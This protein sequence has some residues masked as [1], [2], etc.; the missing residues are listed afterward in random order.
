MHTQGDVAP[1]NMQ[2]DLIPSERGEG[3]A[4]RLKNLANHGEVPHSDHSRPAEKARPDFWSAAGAIFA[5]QDHIPRLVRCAQNGPVP[6][7]LAQERLWMLEQS[8]P[9][10]PYYHIPLT[11]KITG[12]L[13]ISALEQA[14]NLLVQRHEILR[15]VF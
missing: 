11:W 6:L 13:N 15:T 8:E 14:L 7:S 1:V 12:Q 9:G 5:Q 10:A 4:I 3:S 2:T